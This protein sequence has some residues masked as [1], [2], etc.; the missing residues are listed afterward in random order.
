MSGL[1]FIIYNMI[2]RK[3]SIDITCVGFILASPNKEFQ[4]AIIVHT[5]NWAVYMH[6]YNIKQVHY[7]LFVTEYKVEEHTAY[8]KNNTS[9]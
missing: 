6:G 4:H 7:L 2:N 3:I 9:S 1:D 5:T 8:S